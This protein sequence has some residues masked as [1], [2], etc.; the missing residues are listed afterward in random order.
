M[1]QGV[2]K[3]KNLL[4]VNQKGMTLIEIMIA[5]L[6]GL[7]LLGGIYQIFISTKHSYR[8]QENLGR[9]QESGRIAMELI[10]KDLRLVGFQGCPGMASVPP[11]S[12]INIQGSNTRPNPLTTA[13]SIGTRMIASDGITAGWNG[14]GSWQG[15]ATRPCTSA[16]VCEAGTDAI[17]VQYGES[18]GGYVS[19]DLATA[20]DNIAI[21]ATNSCGIGQYDLM[22]VSDCEKSEIFVV[23]SAGTSQTSIGHAVAQNTS[24]DLSK[25]YTQSAELL[26]FRSY[27]YYIRTNSTTGLK[28]LYRLDNTSS[29]GSGTNPVEVIEGVENLQIVYGVDSDATPDGVANYYVPGTAANIPAADWANVVSV[30]ISLLLA[31]VDNFLTD[32]SV[33]Y[34]F[35]GT[36]T[37]PTDRRIRRVI[38]S[39]VNLRNN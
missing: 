8:M 25:A 13:L 39:T 2:A 7:F 21:P 16:S 34:T 37:T 3:P 19:A 10:T 9:L 11:T 29:F 23:S 24:A 12:L 36:T 35:N 30:R 1:K 5:L 28:S 15:G 38:T 18:C 22:L 27:S 32:K 6:V 31:S 20:A 4:N 14:G 33:P 17:T 26:K